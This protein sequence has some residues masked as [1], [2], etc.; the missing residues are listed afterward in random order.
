M[1]LDHAPPR[2]SAAPP[3]SDGRVLLDAGLLKQLRKGRALSQ[4]ALAELC[5]TNQLCVSIASIKRAETGKAVLYRTARH[6]ATIFEVDVDHLRGQA[7]P[8]DPI[9][10]PSAPAPVTRDDTV[11]YVIEL[12]IGLTVPAD[13][14]MRESLEALVRHFG[15]RVE[16]LGAQHITAIFGVPQAY[17]SDAERAMRCALEIGQRA[18]PARPSGMALRLARWEDGQAPGAVLHA[19]ERAAGLDTGGGAIYV[20]QE[21][22]SQLKGGFVF[23]AAHQGSG[24]QTFSRLATERDE[25]FAPMIGRYAEARQFKGL[26][27][28]AQEYQSGHVIYLRGMAGIGKSRLTQEFIAIARENGLECHACEVRDFGADSWLAPFAQL[29]RGLFGAPATPEALAR[30][31]DATVAELK[32]PPEWTTFYRAL[33]GAP[34]DC[35]QRVLEAAM[36]AEARERA[37]LAALQ[38]LI[39]RRSMLT[40]LMLSVED[41]HWGDGH[42]FA[43]LG[44]L[45]G[46]TR[47]APVV[48]VLTSRIEHDP[49][50]SQLRAHLADIAL[51]VFELAPLNAREANVLADQY[52]ELDPAWRSR[53]VERAQGNPLFLTQL[54]T[55]AGIALPDS[56]RHL[57]QSRVDALEPIHRAALRLASVMGNRF[58]LDMLRRALDQPDYQP[59]AAGRHC[60]VRPCGQG[61]YM[62]V[63]DLVMHCIYDAIDA[64]QRRLLHRIVADLYRDTDRALCAHHLWR[65][66]DPDAFDMALAA[67]R[68]KLAAREFD[69][70][71]ELSAQWQSE[72]ADN[73]S[74]ALLRAHALSGAGQTPQARQSY[75]G[76]LALAAA[77]PDKIEAA[78]GLATSL[79]IL[80]QLDEEERLLDAMLPLAREL[81]AD[82]SLAKLLYLKGNIYFPRG[83]YNAC[84]QH[85]E[86]AVLHARAGASVE[87]EI[88][89]L[90]GVADSYYAQGRMRQAEA[91][92]D[93]CLT[94][95]ATHGLVQL[96]PGNRFALASTRLYLGQPEAAID[97]AREAAALARRLGNQRAEIVARLTA[98]W[99]L[100]AGGKLDRAKDEVGAGLALSRAMG[101]A[102]FEP[103]LMESMARISWLQGDVALAQEQIQWA[104]A[105]VER[106]QLQGFIGPWVMGTLALLTDDAAVRARALRQGDEYL[107]RDCVAHNGFR[108]LVA[109]AEVALI[110]GA[111]GAALAYAGRLGGMATGEQCAWVD[112]HVALLTQFAHWLGAPDDAGRAALRALRERGAELGFAHA[113]PRL[114]A[115]LEHL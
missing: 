55:S 62:F 10:A 94:M 41:I 26:I 44:A 61:G 16:V 42:L 90:S 108:F 54:L 97:D 1:S 43:A 51:S 104:A 65:C 83:N 8:S 74:L 35:G 89:A 112:H 113:T 18:A 105:E 78:L 60:L 53:C 106:L 20:A 49:L 45:I 76:A 107:Q 24:Y 115:A 102:R 71:L 91:L 109:A 87:T 103:F 3:P 11:R 59:E 38:T 39:V 92:F 84:R 48:W 37:I 27:E 98:G 63:H 111:A 36:T 50:E 56:L 15:G 82:A 100:L 21:L 101:A 73:F 25:S 32:L 14:A 7:A 6:L 99:V 72:H 66:D 88:R 31:I 93:Q 13:D 80:E 81:G 9:A 114:R 86:Q 23:D 47:E 34:M 70:A 79:N 33:T 85:H 40:P 17:S 64:Q 77:T 52:G 58:E 57:I 46:H 22:V 75:Q 110:D 96:E 28:M 68:D 67:L 5:F 19:D 69:A 12:H 29:A 95:C 30:A 2:T 4:E